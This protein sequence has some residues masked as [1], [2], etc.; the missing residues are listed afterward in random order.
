MSI[1]RQIIPDAQAAALSIRKFM[2]VHNGYAFGKN[3]QMPVSKRVLLAIKSLETIR[4]QGFFFA[5]KAPPA[6]LS[7]PRTRS[8]RAAVLIGRQGALLHEQAIERGI[9]IE[10]TLQGD[11]GKRVVGAGQ[12]LACVLDPD[13]VQIL[14]ERLAGQVFEGTVIARLRHTGDLGRVN[15]VDI[16]G[17]MGVDIIQ[18][19]HQLVKILIILHRRDGKA[20]QDYEDHRQRGL[21]DGLVVGIGL[22]EFPVR[23][24]HQLIHQHGILRPQADAPVQ[25]GKLQIGRKA[26]EFRLRR[27]RRWNEAAAE[28]EGN[29]RRVRPH[30]DP[31]RG[32]RRIDEAVAPRE[33]QMPVADVMKDIAL[34]DVIDLVIIVIV[35]LLGDRDGAGGADR[36]VQPA[37]TAFQRVIWDVFLHGN[38]RSFPVGFRHL[39]CST[40][41]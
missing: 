14:L 4:F 6:F 36:K 15:G 21:H 18:R 13:L 32:I 16:L 41:P 39:Y 31:V 30:L 40:K 2:I 19:G 25:V 28:G 12:Q 5:S 1:F 10:A 38:S 8:S 17:K 35:D 29:K 3:T 27:D 11:G 22:A 24:L 23:Q 20:H 26:L 34:P 7:V 33:L 37:R 9:V